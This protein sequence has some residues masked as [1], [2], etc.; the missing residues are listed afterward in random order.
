MNGRENQCRKPSGWLGRVLLWNMNSRHSRVTDWGL[1]HVVIDKQSTILDVGCGGGR[2]LS[3]LAG[4]APEGKI[5]GVDHSE[6]SVV[7]STKTNANWIAIG[8]VQVRHGSVSQLPFPDEMFDLVTAVETHFWWPDMLAGMREIKR[9]LKIGGKALIIAEVYKGAASPMSRMI[10]KH[11]P[12]TGLRLLD[13]EEHRDLFA[14]TGYS[15]IETATHPENGW[16][17]AAGA[18]AR[19]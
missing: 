17:C 7:A 4:M 12:K 19:F 15:Q 3:K 2:T 8:R 11:A 10:E 14:R 5:Y 1:S 9:V 16:I 18:N 6:A 13:I